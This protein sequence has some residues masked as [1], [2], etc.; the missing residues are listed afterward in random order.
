MILEIIG[1]L[2]LIIVLV[3]VRYLWILPKKT[4]KFYENQLKKLNYKS[5]IMT[6]KPLFNGCFD[7]LL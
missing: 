3:L 7:P 6:Y 1:S 4:M 5:K 2:I